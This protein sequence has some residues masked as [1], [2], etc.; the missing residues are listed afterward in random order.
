MGYILAGKE[1]NE[2][3]ELYY[4]DYGSGQPVVL[5]HGFPLSGGAWE[6]EVPTLLQ[7]GYRTVTYDRRG[8]GMSSRPS[9]GYDYD[10]FAADLDKLMTKLDLH[11]AVLVGHSMGT[12]EVARYLGKY[13]SSRVAGAVFV[14]PIPPYAKKREDNPDGIAPSTILG[15]EAAIK[16]D[17]YAYLTDFFKNFYNLDEKGGKQVSDEVVR[18]DFIVAQN[19]SPIAMAACPATWLTDF[20]QD[21]QH[22]DV[23]SLIIQGSADRILPLA[24][25]GEKLHEALKGSRLNVLAG[26]SHGIPWTHGQEIADAILDFARGLGTSGTQSRQLAGSAR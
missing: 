14:S 11:N 22:I 24:A 26:A 13:G 6:K 12:G 8:F 9:T 21:V 4:Q 3:I 7:A 1:Q 2:P 20:R 5:I 23:P 15:I 18:H 25:T 10:T 16:Q 19:S 17:R